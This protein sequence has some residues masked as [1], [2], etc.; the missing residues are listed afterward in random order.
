VIRCYDVA[1]RR[2]IRP[3]PSFSIFLLEQMH[4]PAI[5]SRTV[6]YKLT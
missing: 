6:G 4:S 5:D 3:P 1:Y 2:W